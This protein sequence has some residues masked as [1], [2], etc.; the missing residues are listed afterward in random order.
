LLFLLTEKLK[1]D[2]RIV[3]RVSCCKVQRSQ[4]ETRTRLAQ[5]ARALTYGEQLEYSGSIFKNTL[6]S[7]VRGRDAPRY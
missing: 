1:S 7:R 2:S 5:A 6:F 3:R 4:Y